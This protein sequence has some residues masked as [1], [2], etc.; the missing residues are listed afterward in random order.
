MHFSSVVFPCGFSRFTCHANATT[1]G[2]LHCN[3]LLV[4]A[5]WAI[6]EASLGFSSHLLTF[7]LSSFSLTIIIY[8][9]YYYY[10]MSCVLCE[11][12]LI[13]GA[14]EVSKRANLLA[15]RNRKPKDRNRKTE[16]PVDRKSRLKARSSKLLVVSRVADATH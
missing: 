3:E 2:A 12:S 10:Y 1:N 9:Y 14:L 16:K 15:N 11:D 5:I 4:Q 7:C 13:C 6:F 8:I